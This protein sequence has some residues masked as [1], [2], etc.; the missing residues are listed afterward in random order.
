ML[1]PATASPLPESSRYVNWC[2]DQI[3]AK[4]FHGGRKPH[5]VLLHPLRG[6]LDGAELWPVCDVEVVHRGPPAEDV[7][8]DEEPRHHA[9]HDRDQGDAG[10]GRQFAVELLDRDRPRFR[11]RSL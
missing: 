11:E 2:T 5:G 8:A 10:E 9:D 1:M 6:A 3:D 7:V 4:G